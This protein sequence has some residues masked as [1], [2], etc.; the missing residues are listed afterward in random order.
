MSSDQ[1][2]G[3]ENSYG[4]LFAVINQF[5]LLFFDTHKETLERFTYPDKSVRP[6]RV[7]ANLR[8]SAAQTAYDL[9]TFLDFARYYHRSQGQIPQRLVVVSSSA[10][11]ANTIPAGWAGENVDFIVPWSRQESLLLRLVRSIA[12]GL[13]G[14]L[15]PRR[16]PSGAQAS[17]AVEAAWRLDPKARLNALFWWWDSDIPPERVVHF[18]VRDNLLLQSERLAQAEELGIRNVVLNPNAVGDS[19]HLLWRP[20]P[21]AALS[22]TR[23]LRTVK[24]L[25]WGVR[26][27]R[28]AR[29]QACRITNMLHQSEYFTDF[30]KAFNIRAVLEQQD[31]GMDYVSIACDAAGA[32]RIGYHWSHVD[33]PIAYHER[34]HQVY[35]AWGSHHVRVMEAAGSCV[36]HVLL[37]GC[38]VRGAHPDSDALVDQQAQRKT[39]TDHGASRVIALF[40]RTLA[41]E[42]FY[43]FF[44]RKVIEDPRWGLLIKP[45]NLQLPWDKQPLPEL[46]KLYEQASSTGRVILLDR[47]LSPADAAAVADFAVGIDISSAT[48]VAGLGGNRAIHLDYIDHQNSPFSEWADISNAGQGSLVFNDPE[49][50]WASLNR[51]FDEPD[52]SNRL[53]LS[54][55]GL[56]EDPLLSSID[57]FRDGQSGKRVGQYIEW[58]LEALDQGLERDAALAQANLRFATEWGEKSVIKGLSPCDIPQEPEMA[59]GPT[60]DPVSAGPME[61]RD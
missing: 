30:L 56:M 55:L 41:A 48:V 5:T 32:A 25:A 51:Y 10:V 42:E 47:L 29:W 19:P 53:G 7:L 18:I 8:K 33:W 31:S 52:S 12:R 45:K 27:G 59:P 6:D 11:L 24:T 22:I 28:V 60:A 43:E 49:L 1:W 44:L 2:R 16:S 46:K 40:D 13:A 35:F 21:G 37:S 17:V 61:N 14:S 20:S 58:Y 15:R 38:I 4:Q 50:L 23:V 26:K 36:D 3:P 39:L 57:P 34:L 9:L 54:S